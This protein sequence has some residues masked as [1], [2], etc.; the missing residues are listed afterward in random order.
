[1]VSASFTRVQ[2]KPEN[3]PDRVVLD[4]D[5]LRPGCSDSWGWD[6]QVDKEY[7]IYL[8]NYWPEAEFAAFVEEANAA[9]ATSKLRAGGVV[10]NTLCVL[11]CCI[12]GVC[13]KSAV[14]KATLKAVDSLRDVVN[15]WNKKFTEDGRQMKMRVAH[16]RARF[17]HTQ[18]RADGSASG[19]VENHMRLAELD[20]EVWIEIEILKE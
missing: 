8:T 10:L 16:I 4:I 7:P 2:S 15:K 18:I 3:R 6:M 20:D 19:I 12:G 14:D 13:V 17:D 1:M 11:T 9:M 5:F